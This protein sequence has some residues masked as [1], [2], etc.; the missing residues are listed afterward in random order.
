L[1]A[2][3]SKQN[4]NQKNKKT[5]FPVFGMDPKEFLNIKHLLM[6]VYKVTK[7]AKTEGATAEFLDFIFL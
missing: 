6:A 5:N 7:S 1:R 4:K 3:P 2:P